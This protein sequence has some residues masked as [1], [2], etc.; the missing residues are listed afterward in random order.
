M[1]YYQSRSQGLYLLFIFVQK[2]PSIYAALGRSI[3]NVSQ[4][5]SRQDN[6]WAVLQTGRDI[7]KRGRGRP[8][9]PTCTRGGKSQRKT[10]NPQDES[11]N[12]TTR[13]DKFAQLPGWKGRS[14]A[15]GSSK[16]TSRSIRNR[17]KPAKRAIGNVFKKRGA[18]DIVIDDEADPQQVEW[19]LTKAPVGT[20]EN[21]N[22]SSSGRSEFDEDN[23]QASADEFDE[24]MVDEF[25]GA[26]SGKSGG[27]TENVGYKIVGK[28]DDEDDVDYVNY[29]DDDD[30][31]NDDED[32][33]EGMDE[34]D[35]YYAEGYINSDYNE[36]GKRSRDGEQ[37]GN[38]DRSSDGDSASSSSDYS[39]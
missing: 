11:C 33:D 30:D 16:K 3:D 1:R 35:D 37:V 12:L 34:Q 23:G 21:E 27:F 38:V 31:Y 22:V 20:A 32:G 5:E 17:Q 15:R 2:F 6:S 7:M 13:K 4:A 25:S 8:R 39:Y 9:G 19:N 36:E 14:R 18:K 29:E 28:G 26:G 10:T 24:R